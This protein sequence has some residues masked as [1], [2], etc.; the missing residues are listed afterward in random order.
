M[1][2]PKAV[3]YVPKV[4]YDLISIGVFDLEGCQIKMENGDIMVSYRDTVIL[5]G[6]RNVP[7]K[8]R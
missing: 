5:E 4:G 2:A 1:H 3:R 8:R 7:N 6:W